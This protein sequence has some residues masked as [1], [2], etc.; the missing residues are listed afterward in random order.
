MRRWRWR[1]F[2]GSH[3][4]GKLTL[5]DLGNLIRRW[6]RR[7]FRDRLC[8]VSHG[9]NVLSG[10]SPHHLLRQ[11]SWRILLGG[12]SRASHRENALA[13]SAAHRCRCTLDAMRIE[14]ESRPTLGALDNHLKSLGAHLAPLDKQ[15]VNCRQVSVT[16][17][18]VEAVTDHEALVEVQAHVIQLNPDAP[19]FTF[20][21]KSADA[22]RAWP[23]GQQVLP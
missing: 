13:S 7:L 11:G 2:L 8:G 15:L 20:V 23:S 5:G 6:K 16:F 12:T 10:C 19:A 9:E 3:L 22:E 18:A 17:L 21:D 1:L 4:R 14:L